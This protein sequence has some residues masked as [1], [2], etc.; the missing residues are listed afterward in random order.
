MGDDVKKFFEDYLLNRLEGKKTD[1]QQSF[2]DLSFEERLA[3]NKKF[4]ALKGIEKIFEDLPKLIDISRKSLLEAI[5]PEDQKIIAGCTIIKKIGFGGMGVVFL[6]HQEK[7]NR[8]VAIKVLP[9][10][11]AE[12]ETIASRFKRESKIIAQLDHE[13]IV[14]IHDIGEENGSYYII[15][16][17]IEGVPLNVLIEELKKKDRSKLKISDL[18]EI[19]SDNIPSKEKISFSLPGKNP[20]DYFCN[21]VIKVA[22]A[23]EYAHGKGIIHRDVKP[24]N[25]IIKANGEPILLDFGLGRK[26]GETSR[27]LSG[28]FLGTPVYSAPESF[29]KKEPKKDQLLDV[30]SLGATLYELLTGGLPYAGDSVYEIYSNLK[31]KEPLDPQSYWKELPQDLDT[32]ILKAIYK[33][34]SYRYDSIHAFRE[35]L[36]RFLDFE[37]ILA[38]PPS[39]F[40]KLRYF[41]KRNKPRF[42]AILL[43]PFLLAALLYAIVQYQ[44]LQKTREEKTFFVALNDLAEA[45]RARA[46]IL[47]DQAHQINHEKFQIL[48]DLSDW[49]LEAKPGSQD[50]IASL[51]KSVRAK[52]N[53]VP[54]LELLAEAYLEEEKFDKAEKTANKIL[55]LEPKNYPAYII[56]ADVLIIHGR[57]LEKAAEL[58]RRF[59][60]HFP[61]EP[62]GNGALGTFC[63]IYNRYDCAVE[64]LSLAAEQNPKK[65]VKILGGAYAAKGNF[66]K[67]IE[68]YR[69]ALI[70]FPEDPELYD[71]IALGYGK[72]D[73][74][75]KALEYANQGNQ[76]DPGDPIRQKLINSLQANLEHQ[77]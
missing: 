62:G 66:A 10:S 21:M 17:F 64:F 73:Q 30:Y 72:L 44:R 27:T 48:L 18:E 28:E 12:H 43:I 68:A 55:K 5:S 29:Q 22:N 63:F 8:E 74:F 37:P 3:L 35:D 7:L 23:L 67:A 56:L 61:D 54:L 11:L 69:D 52:P 42:V 6:A 58:L 15:M 2:D 33:D 45:H 41:A 50:V 4:A 49:R 75:E 77:K 13:N 25:I 51:E 76:L 19:L 40:Q 53:D 20:T 16:K 57:N 60:Q 36:Q 9:P 47:L 39:L 24:G 34:P 38:R 71:G 14:P 32:V 46:K 70:F 31:T 59:D 26:E 1:F 65:Y